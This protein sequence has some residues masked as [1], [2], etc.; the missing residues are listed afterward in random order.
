VH[1]NPPEAV[2]VIAVP[3]KIH[4]PPDTPIG[5]WSAPPKMTSAPDDTLNPVPVTV[6][7]APT[8]PCE[9]FT[10]IAGLNTQKNVYTSKSVP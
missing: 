7:V 10:V 6:Y 9:G 3:V 8:E 1:T 5:V 2:V 4:G